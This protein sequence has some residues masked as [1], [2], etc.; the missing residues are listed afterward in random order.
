MSPPT[1]GMGAERTGTPKHNGTNAAKDGARTGGRHRGNGDG[2]TNRFGPRAGATNSWSPHGRSLPRTHHSAS[3]PCKARQIMLPSAPGL[4]QKSD[5]R[6]SRIKINPISRRFRKVDR[7][8]D[9]TAHF[10]LV[11]TNSHF[12]FR[13]PL[14]LPPKPSSARPRVGFSP[15]NG[16]ALGR[17]LQAP[18]PSVLSAPGTC[19]CTYMGTHPLAETEWAHFDGVPPSR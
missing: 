11:R 2:A 15:R 18:P 5:S 8:P 4:S 19:S 17:F 9:L 1:A 3:H 12:C 7:A 6:S 16:P 10:F 13:P 14:S